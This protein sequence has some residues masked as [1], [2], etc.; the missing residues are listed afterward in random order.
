MGKK[1]K[2][3]FMFDREWLQQENIGEVI[4]KAWREHQPGSRLYK[5]QCKIKKVS[6]FT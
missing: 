5:V 3:R 6:V 1:W 4:G 2:K